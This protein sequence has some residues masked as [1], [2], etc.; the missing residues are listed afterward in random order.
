[1]R[2]AL[3]VC[4]TV[5][6]L[7]GVASADLLNAD[8]E[9][10]S[11]DPFGKIDHWGPNGGWAYHAD[12]GKPGNETLGLSFGF[13]SVNNGE[14]VGQVSSMTFTEGQTYTFG[15]YGV[16]GGNDVGTMVYEI[17]YDD[18]SGNFVLLAQEM[19]SVGG[20]WERFDGVSYTPTPGDGAAG[21]AIWVRLGES[22]GNAD[23]EDV[24]FDGFYLVPAPSA[25]ALLGMGMVVGLRRRR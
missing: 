21:K 22:D 12:F 17:G 6:M 24:W 7:T 14:T 11:T 20:T 3:I 19:Y 2:T 1:M 18:G 10:N 13:Y 15:S 9:T 8:L 23:P 4:G 5:G 16:G 25:T